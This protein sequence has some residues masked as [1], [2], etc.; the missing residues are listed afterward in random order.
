MVLNVQK[1]RF[2]RRMIGYGTNPARSRVRT[3][4]GREQRLDVDGIRIVLPPDHDLPFYQRRDPTYDAYAVPLLSALAGRGDVTVIDVGANV[5]DTAAAVL[6]SDS[7]TQVISVEG[8]PSFVSYLRR[9][10]AEHSERAQVVPGFVGPVGS[11]VSYS[12]TGT[13]GGF[14]T[15]GAS[16]EQEITAWVTPASL[17]EMV[18]PD[19]LAVWKSDIDGFD[20]HVLVQHWEVVDERCAVIWVEYD[21]PR[22]LGDPADVDRLIAL[23]AASGREVVVYDN[24]GR[25][26]TRLAPGPAQA[27]ALHALTS[28]LHEQRQGHVTVPYLDL[29]LL[30]PE[31]RL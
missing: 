9:N 10:L 27:P 2:I 19:R 15:V 24:L 25:R 5:G 6:A 3:L 20:I 14:N 4:F 12:R 28:W 22:T 1:K 13:T 16:G 29:W 7:S 18:Q 31:A 30:A 8:D 23:I 17:L 26:M 11:R 21:P